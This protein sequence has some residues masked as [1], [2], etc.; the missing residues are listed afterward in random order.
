MS[1][2]YTGDVLFVGQGPGPGADPAKPLEGHV[3]EK[4]AFML[5]MHPVRFTLDYARINLNSEFIGKS[6]KGDIFDVAEGHLAAKVLLRGSWKRYVL[7]GQKVA[8]C[9]GLEG[10]PLD[11]HEAIGKRFLLFPHPSGINRWWNSRENTARATI[12]LR[13]FL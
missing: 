9:F 6:G 10:E 3:A 8:S 7:L 2:R 1:I 13:E 11:V 5:D 12:K 4:F